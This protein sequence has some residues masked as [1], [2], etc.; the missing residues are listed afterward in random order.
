MTSDVSHDPRGQY[1]S[2][3]GCFLGLLSSL[4]ERDWSRPGL[5]VWS[6]RDLAGHA[7]RALLTVEYYLDAAQTT[8]NPWVADAAAYYRP[9]ASAWVD[10]SAVAERGRAAGDAL[11]DQPADAVAGI[12][13]RVLALVDD[14]PD[15]ALV[16]T[17]VGTMT[18]TGYLPT[19]TFE[20]VVHTLDLAAA[21]GADVPPGLT[22]P[23]AGCLQLAARVATEQGQAVDV[24]LALTGRRPLPTGFSIV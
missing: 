15:N 5:G 21:V 1:R 22:E 12:V 10:P 13:A 8:D 19:R 3:A 17:P 9:T 14:S 18:L 23:L 7:S 4:T 16:N 2:A 6:V 20:L 24:L 11:G